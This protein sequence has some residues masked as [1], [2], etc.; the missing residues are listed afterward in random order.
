MSCGSIFAGIWL[1][2]GHL[3]AAVACLLTIAG[4]RGPFHA[5]SGSYTCANPIPIHQVLLDEAGLFGGELSGRWHGVIVIK[6]CLFCI[7][8]DVAQ[9]Y[10][11]EI[12]RVHCS[13]SASLHE[14]PVEEAAYLKLKAILGQL[15]AE[16]TRLQEQNRLLI[17]K[18]AMLAPDGETSANEEDDHASVPQ[19]LHL[20]HRPWR[21]PRRQRS[22]HRWRTGFS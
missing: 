20:S 5:E 18:V 3:F 2:I 9:G 14:A 10:E 7:Q 19:P 17:A 13:I 6:L 21:L 15:L 4:Y 8:F 22:T 11:H 1:A 16:N 12:S